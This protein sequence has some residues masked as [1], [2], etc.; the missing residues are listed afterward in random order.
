MR[1]GWPFS[2]LRRNVTLFGTV[3]SALLFGSL[4]WL[5]LA[6]D[7]SAKKNPAATQTPNANT[8]ASQQPATPNLANAANEPL[9]AECE[10]AAALFAQ[11]QHPQLADLLARL[12]NSHPDQY[13][14]AIRELDKTRQRLEKQRDKDRE[15]YAILLHEWQLVSR[16]R[17]LAARLTMSATPELE[18]ELRQILLERHDVRL[19]LLTFDLER[20]KGRV[21]KL[22]DQ[23]VE[24]VQNRES[25]VDRELDRIKKSA[26]TRKKKS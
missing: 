24:N 3:A 13:A 16:I 18:H 4:S 14:T 6:D 21:Q 15:R 12:K 17:L 26:E 7:S 10:T 19:Q 23:I 8:T 2:L 25:S 22:N 5:A 9:S 20:A 1:F 11:Q